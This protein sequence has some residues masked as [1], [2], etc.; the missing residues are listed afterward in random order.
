MHAPSNLSSIAADIL[1][2]IRARHPRV[3][4]ITNTVAQN[5]TANM[6]LAAGAVPSMTVAP[7]EVAHFVRHAD[8]LVVNLGTL[9]DERRRAVETAVDVAA[10]PAGTRIPWLVD[11]VFIDRSPTRAAFAA[12][13]AARRPDVIRLNRAE[14]AQLAGVAPDDAA[15]ADYARARRT[16]IGLTGDRDRVADG[17]RLV[18][19]ANGHPLMA[20]VTAMGCVASALIGACLAVEPDA[21]LA[22]VAGLILIGVAGEIAAPR[23]Q[24]PGT[25][26]VG[27]VDA[28]YGLE[29][30]AIIER[31]RAA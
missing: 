14:F 26:A 31:A 19:I 21:W 29:K 18:A 27:I 7:E 9:D 13:L 28:L 22:T 16:V 30:A 15:L 20:R 1:A 10:A 2:R 3:H 23:A 6:L 17:E 4:C 12:T 11:P 24:G 5:F 25:F 8:A